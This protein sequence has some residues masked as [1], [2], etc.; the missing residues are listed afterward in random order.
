MSTAAESITPTASA[1]SN[2][3]VVLCVDDEDSILKSL[4]RELRKQPFTVL[5]ANSGAEALKIF[6]EH[7]VDLILSDMRMP[8]MT[9]AVLLSEVYKHWPKTVRIL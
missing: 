4:R 9:G 2:D 8:E 7:R 1:P 3:P 5:T 6:E